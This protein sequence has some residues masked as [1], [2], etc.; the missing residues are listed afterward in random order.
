MRITCRTKDTLVWNYGVLW[1][2]ECIPLTGL[3]TLDIRADRPSLEFRQVKGLHK[4]LGE[5]IAR[6]EK[7]GE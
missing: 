2:Q 6:Q 5:W 4:W 7:G 1:L 3:P